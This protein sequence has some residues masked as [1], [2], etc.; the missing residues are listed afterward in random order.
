MPPATSSDTTKS[1]RQHAWST[2][3]VVSGSTS[4]GHHQHHQRDQQPQH[5]GQP[6]SGARKEAGAATVQQWLDTDQPAREDVLD[7][8]ERAFAHAKDK[9]E[10]EAK[11]KMK[12][13][14]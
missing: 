7:R 13:K 3:S 10:G 14:L 8:V 9:R 2:T 5:Y 6:Q 11:M 4:G 1:A 12:T